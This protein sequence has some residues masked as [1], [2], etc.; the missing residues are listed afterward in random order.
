ML[1]KNNHVDVGGGMTAVLER[2]AHRPKRLPLEVEV[3]TIAEL[4]EA[5]AAAPQFVLLDNMKDDEI[6]RA[7]EIVKRRAPAT[8]IEVSGGIT[9]ERCAALARLGVTLVSSGA[10]TTQA[11]NVD[12]SMRISRV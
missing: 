5:L 6:A 11:P 8:R 9:R 12:I 1:V 2:A 3:R 7:L 4:D 10:L